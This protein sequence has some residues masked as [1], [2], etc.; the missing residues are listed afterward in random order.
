MKDT[1][2]PTV[3]RHVC[4]NLFA[5]DGPYLEADDVAYEAIHQLRGEMVLVSCRATFVHLGT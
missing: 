4:L 5:G 1:G 3:A 2:G